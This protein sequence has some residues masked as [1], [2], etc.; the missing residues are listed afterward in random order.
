MQSLPILH[1][2]TESQA[3]AFELKMHYSSRTPY[4]KVSFCF[5]QSYT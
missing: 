4:N 5:L 2:F 1:I 3:F